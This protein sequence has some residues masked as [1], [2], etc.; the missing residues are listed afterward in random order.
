MPEAVESSFAIITAITKAT[1]T[2]VE[3]VEKQKILKKIKI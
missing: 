2:A 1:P 3:L